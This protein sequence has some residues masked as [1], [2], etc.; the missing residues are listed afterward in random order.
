M[1][2]AGVLGEPVG[3][4]LGAGAGEQTVILPVLEDAGVEHGDAIEVVLDAGRERAVLLGRQGADVDPG[5][6]S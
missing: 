5:D 3:H 2:G 4:G 1:G 6:G